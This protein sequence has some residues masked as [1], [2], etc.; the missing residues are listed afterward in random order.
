MQ[1]HH[2]F[3]Y[4]L[5]VQNLRLTSEFDFMLKCQTAQQFRSAVYPVQVYLQRA[6]G[7]AWTG[8]ITSAIM[9]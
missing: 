4:S 7:A 9:V 6:L 5:T 3:C 2:P 8:K 1:S